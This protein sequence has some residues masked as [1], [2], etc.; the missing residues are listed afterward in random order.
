MKKMGVLLK[1]HQTAMKAAMKQHQ[2]SM[3]AQR[4]AAKR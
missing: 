4:A 2:R 1:Q 3:K